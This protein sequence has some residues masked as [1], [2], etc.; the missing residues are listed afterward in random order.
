MH[1]RLRNRSQAGKMQHPWALV[2][3]LQK[4][5]PGS[6]IGGKNGGKIA[7]QVVR[8]ARVFVRH[9]GALAI[10]KKPVH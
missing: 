7:L 5:Q 3:L 2:C 8:Y 10:R 1:A 9:F 6:Q 4:A